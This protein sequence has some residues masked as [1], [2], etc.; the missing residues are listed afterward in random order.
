VSLPEALPVRLAMRGKT[1]FEVR[2]RWG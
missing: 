1:G 2:E